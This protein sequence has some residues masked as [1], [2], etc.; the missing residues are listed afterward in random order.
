MVIDRAAVVPDGSLWE[1]DA[2]CREIEKAAEACNG[3]D[4][5]ENVA[6]SAQDIF[7]NLAIGISRQ[8]CTGTTSQASEGI[9]TM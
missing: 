4:V 8:I 7:D 6:T 1:D 9:A 2:T 5:S 3:S